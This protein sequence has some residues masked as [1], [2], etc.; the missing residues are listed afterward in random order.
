VGF[1]LAK[2]LFTHLLP[3]DAQHYLHELRRVLMPSRYLFLTAFL[4]EPGSVPSFRYADEGA[5]VRW[6]RRGR[7]HAGLAYEKGRF[8]EMVADA[9]LRVSDFCAIFYPGRSREATG[10]D[11]VVLERA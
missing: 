1:A 6:R 3:A 5:G 2:S 7:P 9:R 4:F 8:L 10:Q 11:I